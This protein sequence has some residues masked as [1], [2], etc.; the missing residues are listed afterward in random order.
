MHYRLLP[1]LLCCAAARAATCESLKALSPSDA[2]IAVAES[3]APGS[4]TPPGATAVRIPS[5]FC[6]VSGSIR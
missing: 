2:T 6:R 5:A 4:F 1:L 3:V